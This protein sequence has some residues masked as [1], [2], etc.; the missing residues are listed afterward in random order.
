VTD[1]L[2][3]LFSKLS[4]NRN[5]RALLLTFPLPGHDLDR[6]IICLHHFGLLMIFCRNGKAQLHPRESGLPDTKHWLT[7][8]TKL[9]DD[10][11]HPRISGISTH[12]ERDLVRSR[13]RWPPACAALAWSA[14]VYSTSTNISLSPRCFGLRSCDITLG[15]LILR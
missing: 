12:V 1:F 10:R 15:R 14:L 3:L 11:H 6:Q 13:A 8:A 2:W 7:A 5:R 4:T 9:L